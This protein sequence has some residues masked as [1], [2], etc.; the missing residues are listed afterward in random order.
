MKHIIYSILFIPLMINAQSINSSIGIAGFNNPINGYYFSFD[1]A[2]PISK[3]IEIAPTF[4]YYSNITFKSGEFYYRSVDQLL[5]QKEINDNS[6][7]QVGT[8]ELFIYF[9]P[10]V[11]F[12]KKTD[13]K[14]GAG[15]GIGNH[16]KSFYRTDTNDNITAGSEYGLNTS[17]AARVIYNYHIHNYYFGIVMGIDA[18]MSGSNSLMGL[19]FGISM[20]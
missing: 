6:G 13:L 11:L 17:Y 16:T 4:S 8:A 1:I 18:Y 14:L 12:H 3:S 5:R 19:Q 10:L 2:F 20:D 9:K 15:F 7:E